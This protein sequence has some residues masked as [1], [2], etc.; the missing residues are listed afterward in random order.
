M[1]EDTV[2]QLS[3]QNWGYAIACFAT[4]T[5][6][7]IALRWATRKQREYKPSA[8]P[9]VVRTLVLLGIALYAMGLGVLYSYWGVVIGAVVVLLG[10][11]IPNL[12]ERR[13]RKG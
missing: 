13:A 12:V 11:M 2:H 5:V 9:A 10:V 7:L 1:S 8:V 6:M 3:S 4:G